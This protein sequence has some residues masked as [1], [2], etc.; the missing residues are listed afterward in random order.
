V[1]IVSADHVGDNDVERWERLIM[2]QRDE[3][4]VKTLAR[5]V[6]VR[7]RSLTEQGHY[8]EAEAALRGFIFDRENQPVQRPRLIRE[9]DE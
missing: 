7:I 3:L 6:E 2:N 9:P 8:A 1:R 5:A 4:R